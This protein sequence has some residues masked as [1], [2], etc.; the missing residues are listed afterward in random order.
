MLRDIEWF[1]ENEVGYKVQKE[2]AQETLVI[3]EEA[4]GKIQ[5]ILKSNV[6]YTVDDFQILFD[7]LATSLNA[8]NSLANT[9]ILRYNQA[10]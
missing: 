8:H 3:K 4:L 5:E 10:I 9:Y 1:K 2:L 7:C 6:M